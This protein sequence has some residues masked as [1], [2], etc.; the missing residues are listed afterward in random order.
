[1]E[2][3]FRHRI[4]KKCNCSFVFHTFF[5]CSL[6]LL[7][8]H[9]CSRSYFFLFCFFYKTKNTKGKCNFLAHN[10]VFFL[11]IVSLYFTILTFLYQNSEFIP[12]NSELWVHIWQL[13]FFYLCF[14]HQIKNNA[15]AAFYLTIQT[16]S[17]TFTSLYLIIQNIILRITRYKLWIVRY[18]L[19]IARKK[20]TKIKSWI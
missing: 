2:A 13:L 14:C 11:T 12:W 7:I 5:S 1:M 18:K 15:I 6:S 3:H 17:L 19:A 9:F 16:F 4:K 10:S 20:K 8:L